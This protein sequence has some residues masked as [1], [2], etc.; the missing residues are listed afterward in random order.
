MLVKMKRLLPLALALVLTVSPVK[1]TGQSLID[2]EQ[3]QDQ[4]ASYNTA[5]VEK[6]TFVKESSVPAQVHYP[7]QQMLKV[8]K[9]GAVFVEFGVKA[10]QKVSKGDVLARFAVETS[11]AS[12]ARLE[13]EITR[14]EEETKLGILQREEAIKLLENSDAE[15]LEQERN[16][17]LL[18]KAKVELEHFKY[19]QQ[20]SLDALKQEKKAE[21]ERQNGY[22]LLAPAD[23]KVADFAQLKSGDPVEA[24]TV[25][26]TFIRTDVVQLRVNN[27]A[28]DLRYNLPVKITVG[29]QNNASVLTGRVVAADSGLPAQEQTGYAY[30]SVETDEELVNPKV[31]AEVIRLDN[32]MVADRSAVIAENGKYYVTKLTDGMLQK[33]YVGFG[34]NNT[35]VVW[36]IHGVADG[37]TLIAD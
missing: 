11:G 20:R 15:G 16:S 31:T 14:L 28:G 17:I 8:E 10:G 18:K 2:P 37:D 1:A 3:L 30:I 24:Q 5:R 21:Q 27:P 33:R 32:V 7:L 22:T 25:L 26:M 29:R 36:I 9:N 19:L 35:E 23:G 12:L 6:G 34:A 13:R 4:Q